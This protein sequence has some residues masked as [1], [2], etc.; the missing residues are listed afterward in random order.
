MVA[1]DISHTLKSAWGQ[2]AVASALG[3]LSQPIP[4]QSFAQDR[5]TRSVFTQKACRIHT[6]HTRTSI[7]NSFSGL[8][9][10]C[11]WT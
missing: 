11:P 7:E 5:V 2:A 10:P 4:P 3:P 8:C 6:E 9:A 1:A